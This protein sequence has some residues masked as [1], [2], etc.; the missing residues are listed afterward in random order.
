MHVCGAT[1]AAQ[2]FLS[3]QG[4]PNFARLRTMKTI[5][6]QLLFAVLIAWL[7]YSQNAQAVNPPPDGGYPDG[8]TA[9]G[10]AALLSLTT[11]GLNSGGC[12][13]LLTWGTPRQLHTGAGRRAPRVKI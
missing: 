13:F 6:L 3:R 2:R 1:G 10:Q 4:L 12:F 8:N 11:G 7:A 5:T 9:E